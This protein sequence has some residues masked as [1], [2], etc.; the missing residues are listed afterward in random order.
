MTGAG[1]FLIRSSCPEEH[2]G[3]MNRP[4]G[5]HT[6]EPHQ[7]GRLLVVE[8]DERMLD[9]LQRALRAQG[10][11]VD[12]VADGPQALAKGLSEEYDAALLD[13]MIPPPDGVAVLRDWRAA[14][15]TLPVLLLTA[16]DG[17]ADRVRG[18]DAGADDYLTKPF[19][20]AELFA[21]VERLLQRPPALRATVLT[22]GDLRLDPA[23]HTVTRGDAPVGLSAKEFALLHELMRHPGRVLTR[24]HLLEHL[25]DF[26]YD[27]DSNV[28]DV[29]IGYLRD[30]VD[31]PFGQDSIETVR[32]VGYRL[33]PTRDRA[34]SPEG[35]G[36]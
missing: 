18:L 30:K 11:S 6:D 22:C 34:P 2:A 1:G 19:A 24:S 8:D 32:G 9:F 16:R 36:Q 14:R 31:R 33:R 27:G 21:R 29:Y 23:R 3:V 20:V 25:W 4:V 13:V 35:Q 7:R 28:I 17:V 12:A 10:Y 15:R 26:S 5:G